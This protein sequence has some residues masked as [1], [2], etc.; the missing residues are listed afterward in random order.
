MRKFPMNSSQDILKRCLALMMAALALQA[1]SQKIDA[2]QA[3]RKQGLIYKMNADDPF[4]GT[5]VNFQPNELGVP[6]HGAC[7]V[8]LKDGLLDGVASCV[9][10][11]GAKFLEIEYASGKY[12]GEFKLWHGETKKM[13]AKTNWKNGVKDGGEEHYNPKTGKILS[14][15]NWSGN[16]LVGEQKV[17]DVTGETLLT[18]LTWKDGKKTGYS[19]YDEDERNYKDGEMD[20]VQRQCKWNGDYQIQAAHQALA[21]SLGGGFFVPMIAKSKSDFTCT[22]ETYKDGA[23]VGGE[24]TVAAGA[25]HESADVCFGKKFAAFRKEKGDDVPITDDAMQEWTDEC[26]K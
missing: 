8:H 2:R 22:E 11:N 19:K 21:Q 15:T 13:I 17:W 18:D 7:E 6:V 20:G 4:T 3:Q 10:D 5:L 25:G 26:R 14:R 12:N 23:K 24:N 16:A 9:Y 1:C